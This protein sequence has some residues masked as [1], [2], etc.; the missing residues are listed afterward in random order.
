M[1]GCFILGAV[2]GSLVGMAAG[3]CVMPYVE[4][5]LK[6]T[7]K[8]CRRVL[9]GQMMRVLSSEGCRAAVAAGLI[10]RLLFI[11]CLKH[12]MLNWSFRWYI[13]TVGSRRDI[14]I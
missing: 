6:R 12:C 11:K 5:Q 14:A 8:R 3:M 13:I 4:P 9:R 7:A 1:K 10:R 2:M